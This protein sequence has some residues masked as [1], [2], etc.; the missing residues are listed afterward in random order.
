MR[1]ENKVA[2]ITG[3]S[4]GIG[5]AIMQ[6]FAKEGVK[7]IASDWNQA[8]L[9]QTVS[10]LKAKGYKI[11]SVVGDISQEEVAS[12]LIE[13]AIKHFGKIDILCNN[14][15]IM[16]H[17]HGISEVNNEIWHKVMAINVT[18][19]MFTMRKAMQEML[20]QKSGSIINIAS[21][22]AKHGGAAGVAYTT[23]K[24]ALLGL[25][26]NTA[27]MYAK[28]GIRCNT[29]CPGGTKTN[30]AETM[31]PEKLSPFGL[32][33]QG[34]FGALIPHFLE[35]IDVANLALFL[36]SDESLRINGAVITADAGWDAV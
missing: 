6:V 4:S 27:W 3:A 32:A 1:L 7:I 11:E 35:P 22:A 29:I 13:D 21:T 36:A 18:G 23:S 10:P 8:R 19:P 28:E 12:R 34:Q 24:H 30:I 15:A 2:I 33:R 9:E 25:S 20:K 16:D 31:P 17:M 26:Q 14:A 5:L